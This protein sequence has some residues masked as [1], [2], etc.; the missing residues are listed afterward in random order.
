MS[1]HENYDMSNPYYQDSTPPEKKPPSGFSIAAL[2]LGILSILTCLYLINVPLAIISIILA[3]ISLVKKHG[4][5]GFS[6]AGLTLSTVSLVVTCAVL[7]ILSPLLSSLSD[8][9]KDI[10]ELYSH[11]DEVIE[12]YDKTGSL[13]DYMDK[14]SEGET[15][16]FF[17]DYYGGFNK[18]FNEALRKN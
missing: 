10:G 9:I 18:F 7:Y 6:I 16:K 17:D 14:Y 13:P 11:Y 2:V 1:N 8:F 5:I 4:G 15:G 3:I 12:E